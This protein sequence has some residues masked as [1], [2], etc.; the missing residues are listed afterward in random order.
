[1]EKLHMMTTDTWITL[2]KS[3]TK[4]LGVNMARLS[5]HSIK[6]SKISVF[7]KLKLVCKNVYKEKMAENGKLKNFTAQLF[8]LL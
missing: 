1:M 2:L 3:A 7:N 6:S 5:K 4:F 8:T